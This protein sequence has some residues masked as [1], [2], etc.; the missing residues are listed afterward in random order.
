M[1]ARVFAVLAA[2]MLVAT[3]AAGTLTP[4]GL[5]L[6]QGLLMLDNDATG[7]LRQHSGAWMWNWLEAP[8]MLR[9]L[10]LIP[11]CIG[12]ICAGMATTLSLGDAPPRRRR[13]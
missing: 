6:G 5:T 12:V 3:V 1:A 2:L 9:P 10:W 4:S 7:W 8:F 11:A 13:S